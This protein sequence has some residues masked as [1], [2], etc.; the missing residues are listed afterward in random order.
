M[1][2][3]Q[4]PLLFTLQALLRE[5]SVREAAH[6]LGLSPSVVSRRLS[7]LRDTL[8]DPLLVRV[9]HE[10]QPTP[11]A[12]AIS[13][14][15]D[16]NLAALSRLLR[17]PTEDAQQAPT[18]SF[19]IACAD[20]FLSTLLPPAIAEIT[21]DA[22]QATVEV[23]SIEGVSPTISAGLIGGTVDFYLGPPLGRSEGIVRRR[24][25]DADFTCA[26]AEDHPQLEVGLDLDAYCGLG[27]VLVNTR[28]PARSVV[29]EALVTIGRRRRVVCHTPY[30]LGAMVLVARSRLVA[31]LPRQP[32]EQVAAGLGVRLVPPP[33][34]LPAV[35]IFLQWHERMHEDADHAWVRARLP[36]GDP[37][38]AEVA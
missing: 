23:V 2:D 3:T 10:M 31:T 36:S 21:R 18:R 15:L 14:T 22:P 27:H 28:F 25:F 20:A 26:L 9:G 16:A 32:A 29:D 11:R 6:V 19:V 8:G 4:L 12:V 34:L 35:P 24:L 1:S 5:C 30:F 38:P 17:P 37:H 33:L 7:A 13:A